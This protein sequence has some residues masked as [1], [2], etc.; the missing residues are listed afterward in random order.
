[1]HQISLALSAEAMGSEANPV[2]FRQAALIGHFD[3]VAFLEDDLDTASHEARRAAVEGVGTRFAGELQYR[4][5]EDA[6]VL[7]AGIGWPACMVGCTRVAANLD[8]AA[9]LAW[10]TGQI[11]QFRRW[12]AIDRILMPQALVGQGVHW[13]VSVPVRGDSRNAFGVLEVGCEDDGELTR[14]D[15]SI[16]KGTANSVA[17]AAGLHAGR[18]SRVERAELAVERQADLAGRLDAAAGSQSPAGISYQQ[19]AQVG[20]G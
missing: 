17:T 7:Q 4:V 19:D 6:F 16:L 1:M 8:T 20:A 15:A 12:D 13:M 2:T 3:A 9:G 10:L 18:T 11:I 14:H 5:D